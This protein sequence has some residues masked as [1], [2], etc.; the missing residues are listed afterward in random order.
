[1]AEIELEASG[2]RDAGFLTSFYY[3]CVLVLNICVLILLYMC[4]HTK[5][6]LRWYDAL[7]Y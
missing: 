3:I 1:V 4:P 5:S 7:G 2:A 6:R